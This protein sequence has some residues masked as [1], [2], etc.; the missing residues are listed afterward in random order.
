VL[1]GVIGLVLVLG[2]L[3]YREQRYNLRGAVDYFSVIL[4]LAVIGLIIPNFTKSTLDATF[5]GLQ[6]L[7]LIITSI[8]IY[9]IFLLIQTISHRSHF[10]SPIRCI[11][12]CKPIKFHP[13]DAL[14]SSRYHT[15]LLAAYLL[16]TLLLT[17]QLSCFIDPVLTNIHAPVTL[18]GAL[19]AILVL[20]PEAVSAIRA[21]L[22]NQ[23]Q[24]SVN[25][26]LGSVLATTALTIPAV[27]LISLLTGKSII[28]GLPT[29]NSTLLLLSLIT[30][31]LTFTTGRTN[32]LQGA[33]HLL[34][35]IAYLI[36]IFD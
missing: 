14:K 31:T 30:G 12:P 34:L 9:I 1:N 29:L 4:V 16:P 26:A 19:V 6:S 13:I 21:S 27:L 32:V 36:M 5:S 35:F 8:T 25:I 20:T 22:T 23:L 28:L 10:V 33:V 11:Q 18:S 3:K 2:G 7:F 17:K 15:F 24:R